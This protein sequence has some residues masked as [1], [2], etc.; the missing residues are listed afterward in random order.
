MCCPAGNAHGD[1]GVEF[2]CYTVLTL[3]EDVTSHLIPGARISVFQVFAHRHG[4]ALNYPTHPTT[5]D[6]NHGL[7]PE[8]RPQTP[9]ASQGAP[10]RHAPGHRWPHS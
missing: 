2:E 3:L 7:T 5:P 1:Q 10:E 4:K 8:A 6:A 9:D